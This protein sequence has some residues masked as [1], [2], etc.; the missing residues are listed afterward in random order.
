MQEAWKQRGEQMQLLREIAALKR[1]D[2]RNGRGQSKQRTLNV[3]VE[4]LA[5]IDAALSTTGGK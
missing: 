1:Y 4:L 3:P 5:R 2:P